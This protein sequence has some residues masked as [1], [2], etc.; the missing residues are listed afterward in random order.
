MFQKTSKC[1]LCE[2]KSL[3]SLFLLNSTPLA[4]NLLKIYKKKPGKFPLELKKCKSCL[5]IQ[6]SVVVNSNKLFKNYNYITSISNTFVKHFNQYSKF[7]SK[8]LI[9]KKKF[10]ILDIGSNDALFLK[11]FPKPITKIAV[12]PA[13]NLNIYYKNDIHLYN[14]FF[15]LK[16]INKI[17]KRYNYVDV[18][19]ANNVFAHI[20]SLKNITSNIYSILKDDGFFIFE[21]SYF[22]YMLKSFS[23]DNVY[24][25]H[26]SYH[27][28]SPLII[29]LKKFNFLVKKIIFVNTHGGSIRVVCQKKQT[30]PKISKNIIKI[31]QNEKIFYKNLIN[32]ISKL[33]NHIFNLGLNIK[34]IISKEKFIGY[35]CPAKAMT[36]IYNI[37]LPYE[38]M[39]YIIDDNELKQNK[40][41]PGYNIK[42]INKKHINKNS[43][44]Y[45]LIFSWNV[46][47]DI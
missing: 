27:T 42:V 25:E 28:L 17:K 13:K 6:L 15:S 18:V 16:V 14:D 40:Y 30:L 34:K 4:N 26:I 41:I 24:H 19:T 38:N 45:V 7:I 46:Y 21:V 32:K 23:F 22:P 8:D 43:F 33:N 36:F 1:R 5:H 11:Q 47:S 12:E 44:K 35:G 39:P 10:K 3:E 2:S 37:N 9:K 29:F 20:S 31:L